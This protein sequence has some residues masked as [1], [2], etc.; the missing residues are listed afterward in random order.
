MFYLSQIYFYQLYEQFLKY[1]KNI[2]KKPLDI[3]YLLMN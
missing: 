3:F 2:F 1:F